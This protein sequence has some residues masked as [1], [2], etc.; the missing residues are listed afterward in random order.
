MSANF[1]YFTEAEQGNLS[2]FVSLKTKILGPIARLFLG[3]GMSPNMMSL[4]S[5][6]VMAGFVWYAEA[7][8]I[9]ALLFVVLH[10]IL[11]NVDGTMARVSGASSNSGALVDIIVDQMVL[12]IGVM[13]LLYYGAISPFW[14]AIYLAS[15]ITMIFLLVILNNMGKSPTYVVRSK[16][17]FF[18]TLLLDAWLNTS[19][20]EPFLVIFGSY[21]ALVAL[22]LL[23]KLRCSI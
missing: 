14:S 5:L 2:R 23:N 1:N 22:Y 17:L 3:L 15:Y 7:N 18:L 12:V 16:Y 6:L 8:M 21:T 4:V 9:Y 10:I 20:M 11:D 19:L 13:T